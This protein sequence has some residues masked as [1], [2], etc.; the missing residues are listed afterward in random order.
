[1]WTRSALS[2]CED[3]LQKTAADRD[4]KN[5]LLRMLHEARAV[6]RG[7]KYAANVWVHVYD[8]KSPA[9]QGCPMSFRNTH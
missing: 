2:S 7:V 4:E 6:R 1:M 8:Y 3:K 5:K 9:S